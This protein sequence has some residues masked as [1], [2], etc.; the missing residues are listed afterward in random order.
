[1]RFGAPSLR[2]EEVNENRCL[3]DRSSVSLSAVVWIRTG[4]ATVVVVVDVVVELN[5]VLVVVVPPAGTLDGSAG[6][7]PAASHARSKKPCAPRHSACRCP[8]PGG[9]QVT[10]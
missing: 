10:G 2:D 5:V 6:A 9:T 7:L 3:R 4:L 8:E 1:M